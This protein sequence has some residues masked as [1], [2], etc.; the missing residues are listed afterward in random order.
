MEY[1]RKLQETEQRL[2]AI[3]HALPALPTPKKL[4]DRIIDYCW[5]FRDC[6]NSVAAI[7]NRVR[8][9]RTSEGLSP[10]NDLHETEIL[11]LQCEN[12]RVRILFIRSELRSLFLVP[13][14]LSAT[15][16]MKEAQWEH[17]LASSQ[18]DEELVT[19]QEDIERISTDQLHTLA[20][21]ETALRD[22]R[23][24]LQ[25]DKEMAENAFQKEIR[26]S[27]TQVRKTLGELKDMTLAKNAQ[28]KS[29]V[30]EGEG[31]AEQREGQILVNNGAFLEELDTDDEATEPSQ[32]M[33]VDHE[34][35]SQSDHEV[36]SQS[37]HEAESPSD[38]EVESQSDHEVELQ[39]DHEEE[40]R[41]IRLNELEEEIR[42]KLGAL[43]EVEELIEQLE[44]EPKCPPRN[45]NEGIIIR[46]ED[47]HMPCVFC[48]A[49]GLHYSDSCA[50]INTTWERRQI[51]KMK[52]RCERCLEKRCPSDRFKCKKYFTKCYH[53]KSS[54]HHSAICFLPE[55]SE[56]VETRLQRAREDRW[57]YA[58]SLRALHHAR[59]TLLHH[60]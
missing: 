3:Q 9:L 60:M 2:R 21:M 18:G 51:L 45:F 53:C 11:E 48:E 28:E 10:F 12:M 36:E 6:I 54:G 37:D 35:E 5:E 15:E 26:D 24:T 57:Q 14:L 59:K 30:E 49:I 40:K 56:D 16:G 47:K 23:R 50:I 17:L 58:T 8:K 39:P 41:R 32:D 42:L 34:I 13:P 4:C 19:R 44:G 52:G 22:L 25:K 7:E 29:V 27:M 46:E 55:H 1:K 31:S 20:G 43:W 33:E 38:H